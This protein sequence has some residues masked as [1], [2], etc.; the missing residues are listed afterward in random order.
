MRTSPGATSS[1]ECSSGTSGPSVGLSFQKV[2]WG[3]S[4]RAQVLA[5]VCRLLS[6]LSSRAS[7]TWG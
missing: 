2:A 1:C 4:A 3:A 5:R 7:Q 6:F